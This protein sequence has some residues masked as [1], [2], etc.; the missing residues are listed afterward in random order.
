M[1]TEKLHFCAVGSK[2][3][4]FSIESSKF[5]QS[6][7]AITYPD[8]IHLCL[9]H[10]PLTIVARVTIATTFTIVTIATI[11]SYMF[12]LDP[13]NH[14]ENLVF[15][16]APG[17]GSVTRHNG[18]SMVDRTV[19]KLCLGEMNPYSII[20]ISLYILYHIN[21]IIHLYYTVY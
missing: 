4:R 10:Q 14:H 16:R 12:E 5:I 3:A 13:L 21:C 19:G 2:P 6:I 20:Y 1:E 18:V 9:V 7:V 11:Y 17:P 15:R 8:K